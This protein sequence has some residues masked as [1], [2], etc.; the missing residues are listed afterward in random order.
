MKWIE[1]DLNRLADVEKQADEVARTFETLTRQRQKR[2]ASGDPSSSQIEKALE[3]LKYSMVRRVDEMER[4][5]RD[6]DLDARASR[7]ETIR[8][9]MKKLLKDHNVS[10]AASTSATAAAAVAQESTSVS[11][12]TG[13]ASSSGPSSATASARSTATPAQSA[14]TSTHSVPK[15]DS[16]FGRAVDELVTVKIFLT[17]QEYEELKTRRDAYRQLSALRQGGGRLAWESAHLSP[18]ASTQA[19]GMYTYHEIPYH[20]KLPASVPSPRTI[21]MGPSRDLPRHPGSIN[22]GLPYRSANPEVIARSGR[23]NSPREAAT[24]GAK[25]IDPQRPFYTATPR[26]NVTSALN[27]VVPVGGR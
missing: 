21:R 7:L 4:F 9:K 25:R 19:E 5:Y 27:K 2:P 6:N 26:T 1:L 3:A 8:L 12:Q 11:G 14:G 20:D 15:I 24:G 10:F 22:D 17:N 16:S 23:A 13:G 18:R